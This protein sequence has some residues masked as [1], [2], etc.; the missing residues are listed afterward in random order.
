[1]TLYQSKPRI[2]RIEAEQFTGG[3]PLLLQEHCLAPGQPSPVWSAEWRGQDFV[4]VLNTWDGRVQL[5]P[6]DWII[7][8]HRN[9]KHR[10]R[11]VSR[12][13]PGWRVQR[14]P[15]RPDVWSAMSGR[16]G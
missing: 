15:R 7:K 1:M 8:P 14:R 3:P 2:V 12:L 10:Q 5:K 6:G 4:V 11:H 13:A 16:A 9:T